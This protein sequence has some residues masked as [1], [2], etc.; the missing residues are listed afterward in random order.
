M[1]QLSRVLCH[2]KSVG[3]CIDMT[4]IRY[5]VG[6]FTKSSIADFVF[7]NKLPLV[8]TFTRESAPAIFDN[9]IKQQVNLC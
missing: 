9:P 5:A 6:E 4:V 2:E 8:T 3:N 1:L 7:A